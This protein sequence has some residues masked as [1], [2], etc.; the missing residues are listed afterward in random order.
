MGFAA[1]A[2][3]S[4][5]APITRL[6]ARPR[7]TPRSPRGPARGYAQKHRPAPLLSAPFG[8]SQRTP[9]NLFPK[10]CCNIALSPERL[11]FV[12]QREVFAWEQNRGRLVPGPLGM[13]KGKSRVLENRLFQPRHGRDGP[14]PGVPLSPRQVCV[15]VSRYRGD[16]E[17]RA[18]IPG[19]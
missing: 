8:R 10:R 14:D 16:L 9:A 7:R 17:E 15:T 13:H 6:P 4:L 18:V 1:R 5:G 3:Q 2:A 12:A 19:F 11:T